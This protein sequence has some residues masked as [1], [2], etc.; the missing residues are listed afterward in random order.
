MNEKGPRYKTEP[1]TLW[2]RV[3][4]NLHYSYSL[5]TTITLTLASIS[6]WT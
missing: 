4:I 3:C 5:G 2:Y 6:P 1:F